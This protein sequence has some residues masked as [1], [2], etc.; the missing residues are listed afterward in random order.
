MFG[1]FRKK[2][3]LDLLA[4]D[5]KPALESRDEVRICALFD[6]LIAC[7]KSSPEKVE[8]LVGWGVLVACE[9]KLRCAAKYQDW[10][11][12]SFPASVMPVKVEYAMF[13]ANAN[14]PDPATQMAREYLRLIKDKGSLGPRLAD[15]PN[16]RL[17]TSKAFLVLTAAYTHMGARSYSTRILR[18][19]CQFPL[20]PAYLSLCRAE[21]ARL[22][23]EL[24][25]EDMQML[26]K[27]WELFFQSGQDAGVLYQLCSDRKCELLAT[28]VD[29][30]EGNFRFNSGFRVDEDEM[31]MLVTEV[32]DRSGRVANLLQ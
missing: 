15:F 28:R 25:D 6:E 10:F 13:L 18:Y 19:A 20:D 23:K 27:R 21:L 1:L 3:S 9:L 2:R 4:R 11:L 22:T 5:L 17:G 24:Q 26:D 14:Q 32:K 31:F 12:Q 8:G 16:I 29:L 7:R 30:I